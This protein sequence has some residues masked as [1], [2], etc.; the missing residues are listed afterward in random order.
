MMQTY[1]RIFCIGISL[2]LLITLGAC[3]KNNSS[4]TGT[5]ST[6]NV[7]NEVP[8]SSGAVVSINSVAAPGYK[9]YINTE[10]GYS[11]EY[12]DF[13]TEMT[14]TDNA[15]GPGNLNY[16]DMEWTMIS[17]PNSIA[18]VKALYN[19]VKPDDSL[20]AQYQ[21]LLQYS[22]ITSEVKGDNWCAISGTDTIS[23]YSN[24]NTKVIM[25][26]HISY[27]IDFMYPADQKDFYQPMAQH[28]LN[29][30]RIF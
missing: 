8:S 26:G 11:L 30:V 10:Y 25:S 21:D 18:F 15:S 19:S 24:Y 20:D 1:M 13:F 12:P 6:L 16:G 14:R 27:K 17:S 4:T 7:P 23:P 2:A 9:L 28:V 3:T 5:P 22:G 29:T